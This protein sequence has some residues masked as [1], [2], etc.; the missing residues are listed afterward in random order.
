MSTVDKRLFGSSTSPGQPQVSR[1]NACAIAHCS[2]V[3]PGPNGPPISCA[4][5]HVIPN[6]MSPP[7]K[8]NNN[9][10]RFVNIAPLRQMLHG[11]RA[12]SSPVNKEL[13]DDAEPDTI[14]EP[15]SSTERN[16][17]STKDGRAGMTGAVCASSGITTAGTVVICGCGGMTGAGVGL[18]TGANVGTGVGVDVVGKQP[19]GSSFCNARSWKMEHVSKSNMLFLPNTSAC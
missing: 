6:P 18:G 13:D 9:A 15:L 14:L 1:A 5:P 4:S 10:L 19:H 11:K 7:P 16:E 2:I 12:S 3:Y 17:V 8:P